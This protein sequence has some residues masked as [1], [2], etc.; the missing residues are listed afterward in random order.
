MDP[1]ILPSPGEFC[2]QSKKSL[3]QSRERF[4]YPAR[5]TSVVFQD[6]GGIQGV[7][8]LTLSGN[9]LVTRSEKTGA[10][11]ARGDVREDG[12]RWP[13]NEI[14]ME[15]HV[16]GGESDA[17]IARTYRVMRE[18]VTVLRLAYGL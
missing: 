12:Y 6:I 11:A 16:M 9:G 2:G 8:D 17:D 15:S 3:L 5:K 13:I 18:E 10:P 1:A 4:I 7:G 14:V